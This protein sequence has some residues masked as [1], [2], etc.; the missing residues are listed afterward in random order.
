MLKQAMNQQLTIATFLLWQVAMEQ[1]QLK[2]TRK[3]MYSMQM[4]R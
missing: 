2:D 3:C 4:T 1:L